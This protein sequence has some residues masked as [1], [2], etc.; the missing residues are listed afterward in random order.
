MDRM[1]RSELS[2]GEKKVKKL[3]CDLDIEMLVCKL[4]K[5]S[6]FVFINETILVGVCGPESQATIPWS[7]EPSG[8]AHG[9]SKFCLLHAY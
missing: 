5:V 3:A 9:T 1:R 6:E 7:K 4:S 2:A 8:E